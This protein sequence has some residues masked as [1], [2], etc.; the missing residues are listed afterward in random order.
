VFAEK[1]KSE[2]INQVIFV[3]SEV[4]GGFSR[5]L[6]NG[7]KAAVATPNSDQ[8]ETIGKNQTQHKPSDY[9]GALTLS[10]LAGQETFQQPEIQKCVKTFQKANPGVTVKSPELVAEGQTDW[11]TGIIIAC[12]QLEFFQAVADKAG[13]NLDN[14]ALLA[15]IKS[16]TQNFAYGSNDYNTLGPQKFDASNGFRLAA[17]DSS[18][19]AA[20]GLKGLG[21]LQNLG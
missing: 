6:D 1:L 7:V 15:A 9:D 4:S 20:G 11:A 18:I 10:G 3:G 14:A 13:K 12:N 17:F 2:G 5:L 21:P 19:G 16:M 8:L